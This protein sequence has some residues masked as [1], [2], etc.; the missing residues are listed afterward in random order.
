MNMDKT[1]NMLH[2]DIPISVIVENSSRE[3]VEEYV[4]LGLIVRLV[5]WSNGIGRRSRS[6]SWPGRSDNPED[7]RKG[8]RQSKANLNYGKITEANS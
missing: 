2:A 7:E 5:N 1:K 4:Y 8:K 3:V 6:T